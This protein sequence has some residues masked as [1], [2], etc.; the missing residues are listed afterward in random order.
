MTDIDTLDLLNVAR[1]PPRLLPWGQGRRINAHYIGPHA[2]L[3]DAHSV[4]G[5]MM[6]D[7]PEE[8]YGGYTIMDDSPREVARHFQA[9]RYAEGRV[10][11]TGL[12]L[13]CFVRMCLTKPSVE[14]ID[15]I[16]IDPSIAEHFGS[17]FRHDPRVTIHVADALTWPMPAIAQWDFAWHDIYCDGN[18]G[19]QKLHAE[20]LM[21]FRPYCW[22]QGAWGIPRWFR[23]CAKGVI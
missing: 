20:L 7:F 19:L 9:V 10:L 1:V 17:E 8:G 3:F 6:L 22:R 16:E 18:D 4:A 21:R 23:R 14:H 5:M 11:K 13:G 15:V 2:F 12:G